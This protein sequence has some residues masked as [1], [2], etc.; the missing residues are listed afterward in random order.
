MISP[1]AGFGEL[2]FHTVACSAAKRHCMV[3]RYLHYFYPDEGREAVEQVCLLEKMGHQR[4]I[5]RR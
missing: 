3:E 2:G 4:C 1:V 5:V